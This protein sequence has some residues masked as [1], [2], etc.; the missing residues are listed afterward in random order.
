MIDV[1]E[2][3]TERVE[4]LASALAARDSF[5]TAVGHELR[6]SVAPL[7][8]LAEQ[9][10]AMSKPSPEQLIPKLATLTR[11]LR[12]FVATVDRVTE[13]AQLRDGKFTLDLANVDLAALVGDV[14]SQLRRLAAAGGVELIVQT[15]GPVYG[16]W[17]RG[18]LGQIV[19]NLVHNAIRYGVGGD[20]VVIVREGANNRVEL[21]V[22]DHGPGI[23]PGELAGIFDRFDHRRTR[24]AGGFGVGLFVVKTLA[25]AMGGNVTASNAV[26]GGALFSVVLPRA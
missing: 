18:R 15:P 21:S 24:A 23:A 26:G 14:T 22:L 10:E 5:I 16:R 20:V 19:S 3:E 11:N 6:N 13:V 2:S 4:S 25:A 12:K 17:D 9:F 7:L 1:E 8:L